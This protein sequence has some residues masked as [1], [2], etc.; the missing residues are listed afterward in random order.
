MANTLKYLVLSTITK[1]FD[2]VGVRQAVAYGIPYQKALPKLDLLAIPDF[3]YGAME[4]WGAVT[5]R[6]TAIFVDP[7]RS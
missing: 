2:D 7:K 6:E 3:E 5:F 1:P 4:N